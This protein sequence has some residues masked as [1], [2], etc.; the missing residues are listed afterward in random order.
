MVRDCVLFFRNSGDAGVFSAPGH[1]LEG[2]NDKNDDI[3]EHMVAHV[4]AAHH[5][6]SCN[7]PFND[8]QLLERHSLIHTQVLD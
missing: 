5:C 2:G 4:S 7:K 8:L 1:W 6:P 3:N